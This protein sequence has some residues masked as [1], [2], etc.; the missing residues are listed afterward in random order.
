M[1]GPAY[2]PNYPTPPKSSNNW[3]WIALAV[4]LALLLV[5][6]GVCGGCVWV[7][8]KAAKEGM[9]GAF[10]S[11][12]LMSLQASSM[13][14][15]ESNEEVKAKIGPVTGF[16][17]PTLVGTYGTEQP[18]IAC[19]FKVNGET[20]T[21]TATVTATREAGSLKP[22]D[23]QVKFG[24]GTTVSVPPGEFSPDLNF[25]IEPQETDATDA[26]PEEESMTEEVVTP[27]EPGSTEVDES[28]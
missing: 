26:M 16:D 27:E 4:L 24:D 25:G 12:E 14:A 13:P 21:A 6:G 10:Q 18:S 5:C 2:D 15:I 23:I 11:V 1:S 28:K 20:A 9:Q 17:P 19:T 8:S 7:A 3:I 22:T